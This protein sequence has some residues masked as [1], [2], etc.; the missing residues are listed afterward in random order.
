MERPQAHKGPQAGP[1]ERLK[2]LLEDLIGFNEVTYCDSLGCIE[3]KYVCY[4]AD[5][6]CRWE[7]KKYGDWARAQEALT[8]LLEEYIKAY[9]SL[10]AIQEAFKQGKAT[11]RDVL[12]AKEEYRKVE[13]KLSITFNSSKKTLEDALLVFTSVDGEDAETKACRKLKEAL[14]EMIDHPEAEEG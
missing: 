8:A 1:A 11:L 3:A 7:I 12:Q 9:R 13:L 6:P 14:D 10:R 4:L 2:Q 5:G